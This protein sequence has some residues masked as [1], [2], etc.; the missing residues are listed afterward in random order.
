MAPRTVRVVPAA[1]AAFVVAASSGFALALAYDPADALAS[2]ARMLLADPAARFARSLHFWSALALLALAMLAVWERLRR[3]SSAGVA[4]GGGRRGTA[5]ATPH[6]AESAGDTPSRL[7]EGLGAALGAVAIALLAGSGFA[8]RGETDSLRFLA[9]TGG[10]LAAIPGIG[11][12]VARALVGGGDELRVILFHHALSFT[13]LAG[14]WLYGRQ[15]PRWPRW[16][17][18]AAIMLPTVLL[19]LWLA[20]A[21]D[22]GLPSEVEAPRTVQ[23]ATRAWSE[24]WRTRFVRGW[25]F[26]APDPAAL[27]G[28]R[29][30]PVALGRPEG[31]LVCHAG[32]TGLSAAHDPR[33][34]GC[35]SCH[36]GNVYSLQA[37]LA[38]DGMLL[39]PGNLATAARTCG[40]DC[41]ADVVV[42][43]RRSL[44]TTLAGIVTVNRLAW[45][46]PQ[47][48]TAPHIASIG[49]SP[50]D[51]HLRQLCALCHL[52]APKTEP[53]PVSELPQG[54]GCTACHVHY[55]S[56][57]RAALE[58][59]R[60]ERAGA[61]GPAGGPGAAP[62]AVHPD[63]ALP[64]GNA[65][66][67]GCHSRSG[68]ISL[69]YDGWHEAN[70]P[71]PEAQP[72]RTRTLED[73]R[74]VVQVAPDVHSTRGLL[75]IDCHT[76]QEVMGDGTLH[77][78]QSEQLRVACGDCHPH[79]RPVTVAASEVDSGSRRI[80]RLRNFPA[81][82]RVL[83]TASGDVLV[84]AHVD[85][86]GRARLVRKRD[87]VALD[88]RPARPQCRDAVHT[89]VSCTGCHTAWAPRCPTCHTRF[90][91]DDK[92]H[93]LLDDRPVQG[94]WVESSEAFTTAPPTLGVRRIGAP[95]ASRTTVEPFVPGMIAS[96]D[97]SR[98]QGGAADPVFRRWYGRAF[99]H[100]VS[101]AGRT[102]TSCH[103]DPV[104]LGYGEGRLD[105]VA[106]GPGRGQWRFAPAHA[107]GPDGLPAD[108]W[109]GFQR[110]R[111]RD[112]SSREDVRPLAVEEQRR[113]LAVGA[114]LTCH[115]G[116]SRV[117]QGL[118]RGE[119][120]IHERL[121]ASCRVP[122]WEA[123]EPA[124]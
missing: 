81:A 1:K 66:C 55:G 46:E 23:E 96:F 95:G 3:S 70:P 115:D 73:E 83:A 25:V 33:A 122:V 54:G 107:P 93:D 21:L 53:G 9:A 72:A 89:R 26:A 102:C 74:V 35:A 112:V 58:R 45:G 61:T 28:E 20:P 51:S 34:V 10:A 118:L 4:T 59:H 79:S 110:A 31:C 44:M 41:H 77:A 90:D 17:A 52:G 6:V 86:D 87:G 60:A 88:L 48:G 42:R 111:T 39:V 101:K 57:A 106:L 12:L 29:P 16:T 8:L 36:R 65:P 64:V 67:F 62:P 71:P 114:C 15:R 104:A 13:L 22:D 85:A 2:V 116:A 119:G 121:S 123:S 49:Q 75:C 69:S 56:D 76:A 117:M 40:G 82:E 109:I 103:G 24:T 14:W 11:P 37:S 120:R 92:G 63:I 27:P 91:P 100:T 38:H 7:R 80:M 18:I 124:R 30:L 108:A 43:V 98:A 97:G 84:N 113:V 32:V 68:R 5:G 19:A 99:S 78:R 105:F 50:A 47:D 94:A